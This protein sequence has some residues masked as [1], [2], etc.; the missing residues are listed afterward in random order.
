MDFSHATWR[1]STR[2]TQN[3]SCVEVTTVSSGNAGDRGVVAVRDSKDPHGPVL[4]LTR[5]DW[6]AFTSWVKVGR[7]N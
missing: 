7:G 3:G 6:R 2:S 5:G 4:A 1:K